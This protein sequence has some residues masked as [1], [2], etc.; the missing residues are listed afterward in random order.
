VCFWCDATSKGV[1]PAWHATR[2]ASVF[3]L[4]SARRI[5]RCAVRL[6]KVKV[7]TQVGTRRNAWIDLRD[8]V[9]IAGSLA[10]PMRLWAPLIHCF[11]P[12][13][14]TSRPGSG[15]W[16]LQLLQGQRNCTSAMGNWC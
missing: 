3:G 13:D 6:Y 4:K 1:P 2:S 11:G 12:A 8:W 15:A 10:A 14:A 16:L 5:L 9:T 7:A